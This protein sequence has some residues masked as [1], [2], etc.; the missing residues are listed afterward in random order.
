M[1]RIS[2][3]ACVTY[4]HKQICSLTGSSVELSCSYPNN[5]EVLTEGWFIDLHPNREPKHL[6]QMPS[7]KFGIKYEDHGNCTVTLQDVQQSHESSYFYKYTFRTDTK[8]L[9]RCNG[10]PGIQLHVFAFA[11][12]IGLVGTKGILR[13]VDSWTVTEGQ[14]I[15]LTCV[16]T[17]AV[18]Q[19]S[20]LSYIWYKNKLKFKVSEIP[21]LYLNPVSYEDMAS[22]ACVL[23]GYKDHP[24]PAFDLTVQ[25]KAQD[26]VS[27]E[28]PDGGSS[29]TSVP[30][31]SH[32]SDSYNSM[33][34]NNSSQKPI[35]KRLFIFSLIS[36]ASTCVGVFITVMVSV[37]V[38]KLKKKKSCA[39]SVTRPP[40]P[41]SDIYMALDI[42]PM[43]A[44]Y[45]T[46]DKM[47]HCSAADAVYEN[48]CQPGEAVR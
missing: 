26:Y 12:T 18:K 4:R 2:S 33:G 6:E 19:D 3:A 23:F 7:Y 27:H 15:M 44:E 16:P 17:C 45:D 38:F 9:K 39:N 24:S 21:H 35:V 28:A 1:P 48:L 22:Y 8:R 32:S 36:G 40:L 13:H 42:S 25:R 41:S 29:T 31:L 20:N 10:A 47:R 43:S 14:S 5:L 37:V 11:V 34:P 30:A 46:L